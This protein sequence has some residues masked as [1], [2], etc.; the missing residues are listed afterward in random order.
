MEFERRG[1]DVEVPTAP[2]WDWSA[3]CARCG[4]VIAAHCVTEMVPAAFD[5]DA[6]EHS[7]PKPA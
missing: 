6:A 7:F 1:W 4:A 3:E 5:H 2:E